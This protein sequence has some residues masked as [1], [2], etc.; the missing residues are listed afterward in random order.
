M[1]DSVIELPISLK[2]VIGE[3]IS[4]ARPK[5]VNLLHDQMKK[6]ISRSW[7]CREKISQK[8]SE[9]GKM[10]ID[11]MYVCPK[12]K[13]EKIYLC[14]YCEFNLIHSFHPL[15]KI[16]NNEQLELAKSQ[17]G[18]F[19]SEDDKEKSVRNNSFINRVISKINSITKSIT[20]A[21]SRDYDENMAIYTNG[22]FIHKTGRPKEELLL[23]LEVQNKSKISWPN[24]VYIKIEGL[25]NDLEYIVLPAANV[26]PNMKFEFWIPITAPEKEGIY[27]LIANIIDENFCKIGQDLNIKLIIKKNT[28]Y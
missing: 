5:I 19:F 13:I 20:N 26:Q 24:S 23:Y 21:L 25:N 14:K 10:I 4:H 9:C 22:T 6:S 15:L 3:E 17:L 1:K 2:K 7:G 28:P 16:K 8:C 11:I 12:C 27:D 18:I